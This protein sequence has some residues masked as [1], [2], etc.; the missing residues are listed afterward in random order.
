M[1]ES[2]IS[3]PHPRVGS[4]GG[5]ATPR[6]AG[7]VR[8][9]ALLALAWCVGCG[10][11]VESRMAEVRALQDVG[12]FAGSIPELREILVV[13]PDLPEANYRLGLALVQTGEA[14]RAVWPL[15]KAMESS[16]YAA[17]AG[18]LLASTH[19]S[20]R[21]F[22]EAVRAANRVLEED[23]DRIAALRVR[24]MANLTGRKLEDA[25]EDA[26]RLKTLAPDDYAV[27][28]LY[29]TVLGDV[30][31]LE[32]AEKENAFVKE[33]GQKQ[34]DP[35]LRVRACLA[36]AVFAAAV[37]NDNEKARPLYED[38]AQR[39]PT[40]VVTLQHI[41]GFFDKIGERDRATEMFR[42]SA[43]SAPENLELQTLYAQ[44][45]RAGGDI[46]GAEAVLKKS[47]E[48]FGS[49]QAWNA[50]ANFYRGQRQ[51]EQAL[52]AIEKVVEL[53][54]GG[55]EAIRFTHADI[56]LD[57][58]RLDPARE[59]AAK[60]EQPAYASLIRGRIALLSGDPKTALA[61]FETGINAWPNNAPARF[62]AGLAARDLGDYE[63]AVSELRESVRAGREETDA[64]LELSRILL[65]QGR[66]REAI[67]F[68]TMA[69][70]GRGRGQ[71]EPYVVAARAMAA[72][73]DYD[74]A[75]ATLET[76]RKVGFES[77]AASEQAMLER[78]A[79]GHEAA[80]AYVEK[81]GLDLTRADNLALLQQLVESLTE[82]GRHPQAKTRIDAALAVTPDSHQ[83]YELRGLALARAGDVAGSAEAFRKAIELE[84]DSAAAHLGLGTATATQ[85]DLAQ[86][87][88]LLDR[89]YALDPSSPQA[90]HSAAQ[91]AL[92]SGDRDGAMERLR[93]VVQ[94]HPDATGARND[95]AFLLAEAGT[96]LDLALSLAE[97]AR[98]RDPSPE[99][100]DTLGWVRLQR[101]E[102]ELAV[103]A[104][105]Q[106]VSERPESATIRYHLAKALSAA[107]N[108]ERARRMLEAA[109]G[110]GS[111]PEAE[112]ARAELARLGS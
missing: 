93:K 4:V 59:V 11:D 62:L 86:A 33:L 79:G 40:D 83:L 24:A 87:I 5:S 105:E 44:R 65:L 97:T 75:R 25:L 60:L 47:V 100:L 88:G 66:Y 95:L 72:Q 27:R 92:A 103:A 112:D 46:A 34:D 80:V 55:S 53:S 49:A 48:S 16:E 96:E 82:L 13:A 111:F 39:N 20:T 12:Q 50:L 2:T 61:E 36:P 73:K 45:L 29:A 6:A 19:L 98:E 71:P 10:G 58:N 101:G 17:T 56:L 31:R 108:E 7:A 94:H 81:S 3:R 41:A 63:R 77:L 52:A 99:V 28:A 89:S 8:S 57:L 84:P 42:A 68:T 37:L 35:N 54:G 74:R 106:A 9:L 76:L 78:S 107:G 64:A 26:E 69:L 30:G 109:L 51:P 110:L 15:Q 70:A 14:S 43:A 22:D 23:P 18:L 91:L 38:C 21:N 32:E 67:T 102:A 104:L 90:A 1:S 85:G